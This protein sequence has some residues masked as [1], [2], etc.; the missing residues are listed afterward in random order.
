[1]RLDQLLKLSRVIKRRTVAASAADAG[2][3]SVNGR[4]AK[5]GHK[6]KIGDEISIEF[7]SSILNI[8]VKDLK[9]TVRKEDADSMYEVIGQ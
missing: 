6:L 4:A 3:V 8:R 7:G 1:M 5:P 9:E 2:R